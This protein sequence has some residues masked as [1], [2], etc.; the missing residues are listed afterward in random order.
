MEIALEA[1][2]KKLNISYLN[3]FKDFK[4]PL[5]TLV[6]IALDI[7]PTCLMTDQKFSRKRA[8]VVPRQLLCYI[9]SEM[10]YTDSQIAYV[11]NRDR[12]TVIAAKTVV[13]DALTYGTAEY[14]KTM[15]EFTTRLK[16]YPGGEVLQYLD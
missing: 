6:E 3:V 12:T 9:A 16:N 1:E 7:S 11:V 10:G 15:Q 8:L 2:Q 4:V 14:I 13:L 5:S